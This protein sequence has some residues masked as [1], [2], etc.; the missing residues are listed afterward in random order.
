MTDDDCLLQIL[1][2]ADIDDEDDMAIRAALFVTLRDLGADNAAVVGSRPR[3][4]RTR[5]RR[6]H[7]DSGYRQASYGT[8]RR[9]CT[10]LK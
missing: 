1:A 9:Q 4:S 8:R 7:P 6:R 10:F 3:K 2:A 5:R